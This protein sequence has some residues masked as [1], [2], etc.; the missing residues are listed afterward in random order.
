M[1]IN[2]LLSSAPSRSLVVRRDRWGLK[3]S[4]TTFF[5]SIS[6][7]IDE[8][9]DREKENAPE[10]KR[11]SR[12]TQLIQLRKTFRKRNIKQILA[13]T[14][15]KWEGWRRRWWWWWFELNRSRSF[16][17]I[18]RIY[19][20]HFFHLSLSRSPFSCED[21][22][23]DADDM[24]VCSSMCGGVLLKHRAQKRH[25]NDCDNRPASLYLLHTGTFRFSDINTN[26]RKR[27]IFLFYLVF[28][29]SWWCHSPG[30]LLIIGSR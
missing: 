29:W 1:M 5:F 13:A 19:I 12:T 30:C 11:M 3:T 23:P 25:P 20:D 28:Q 14:L 15:L 26:N 27:P 21:K 7:L 9:K 4:V 16:S 22:I 6:V 10:E 17:I 24:V 18:S 2:V 8:T